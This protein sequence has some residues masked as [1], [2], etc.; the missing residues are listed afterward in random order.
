MYTNFFSTARLSKLAVI[1]GA[2]IYSKDS[3]LSASM[4]WLQV[5]C[6]SIAVV[7][8]FSN[9]WKRDE[10]PDLCGS[11]IS[12]KHCS[13][14]KT[15][16]M[17]L[18][19]AT[20][21]RRRFTEA[22]WVSTEF[23]VAFAISVLL[24]LDMMWN[25]NEGTCY[26]SICNRESREELS[27]LLFEGGRFASVF[28]SMTSDSSSSSSISSTITGLICAAGDITWWCVHSKFDSISIENISI[29]N[30]QSL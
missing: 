30:S 21:I 29:M 1:S 4:L 26:L 17:Y 27:L 24:S 23:K 13:S 12:I 18:L 28:K 14:V 3:V 11:N 19:S 7:I 10:L 16:R 15:E 20:Q 5:S 25:T 22:R 8:E 6:W 2:K 9:Y